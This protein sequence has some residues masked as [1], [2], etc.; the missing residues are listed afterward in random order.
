MGQLLNSRRFKLE[1]QHIVSNTRHVIYIQLH[2]YI[3][4]YG[5]KLQIIC[6]LCKFKMLYFGCLRIFCSVVAPDMKPVYC[7]NS[8]SITGQLL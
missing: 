6:E 8:W 2:K 7:Y 4:L 3:L 1:C 5:A